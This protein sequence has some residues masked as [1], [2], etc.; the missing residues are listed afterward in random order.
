VYF[1]PVSH[2]FRG[3]RPAGGAGDPEFFAT[4]PTQFPSGSDPINVHITAR[5]ADAAPIL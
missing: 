1:L 4:S 5:P 3:P 2:V